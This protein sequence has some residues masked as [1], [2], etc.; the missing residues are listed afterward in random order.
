MFE[1]QNHECI[2]LQNR[3]NGVRDCHDGSDEYRCVQ[4]EKNLE[5]TV[6]LN[7]T[8]T[9]ETVCIDGI[10]LELAET[11][12]RLAGQGY[13]SEISSGRERIDKGV[14]GNDYDYR[15]NCFPLNLQCQQPECGTT[16]IQ[17][18]V[19]QPFII[20]GREASIEEW[21]WYGSLFMGE[22]FL[23]GVSIIH[24]LWAITVSHCLIGT[25]DTEYVVNVGTNRVDRQDEWHQAVP[26]SKTFEYRTVDSP[27]SNYDLALLRLEFPVIIN[28]FTRPLCLPSLTSLAA[29]EDRGS[30]AECYVIGLGATEDIFS[31]PYT[32]IVAPE[33]LQKIRVHLVSYEYCE[34]IWLSNTDKNG[35]FPKNVLCIATEGPSSPT[36]FG[37]SGSPLMCKADTGRWELFGAVSFGY[38]NCLH[39]LIPTVVTSIPKYVDWIKETTG[40]E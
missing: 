9:R 6:F 7:T 16:V 10:N 34:H 8:L 38:G 5:V 2:P 36:C 27:F 17:D 19:V 25:S 23:C 40:M 1:C 14:S 11:F 37:D 13:V 29:I 3:C 18:D 21:P 26:V 4:I 24:P 35:P 33:V 28:N 15:L 22:Y 32:R 12:C 30:S 31:D 20:N 39:D